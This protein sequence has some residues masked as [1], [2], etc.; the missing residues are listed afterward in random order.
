MTGPAVVDCHHHL[1]DLDNHVYEWLQADPVPDTFLGDYSPICRNYLIDDYL[2]DSAP[3]ELIKSVHVQCEFEPGNPA[4]ETEWLQG[5][6]DRKGFPHGIVGFTDLAAQD[7][8]QVLEAHACFPNIRGIRQNLNFDPD[9][10][11]RSFADRGD[12]LSDPQWRK[13]FCLLERH[14]MSFDLQVL[15]AQLEDA[16]PVVADHPGIPVVLNHAGL[17][18]DRDVEAMEVWRSGMGLLAELPNTAVKL[19]GFAMV[20]PGW[21][22]GSIRPLILE[23]ISIFGVDRCMFASNFPVDGLNASYGDLF[24]VY[25]E[26]VADFS[27][28]ERS[29]LFGGNAER[30]YRL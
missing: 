4:G 2:A 23:T 26:I 15:P 14:G 20:N 18:F 5:I 22:R 30:V 16:R 17:P 29:A 13:G 21:T 7:V 27:E 11:E 10:S 19:S 28:A 24:N 8:S 1:W 6:A 9:N 3:T 12:Y 25:S